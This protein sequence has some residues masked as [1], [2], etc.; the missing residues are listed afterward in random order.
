MK[1]ALRPEEDQLKENITIINKKVSAIFKEID[2]VVVGQDKVLRDIFICLL[3]RGHILL[4]G[5]PGLAKTLMIRAMSAVIGGTFKRIQF[6][7]DLLPTDITGFEGYDPQRG[8]FT[9]KGPVFA[10]FVLADE[11]NRAPPKVQSAL[12]EVMQ[13][14]Q[15][16]IGKTTFPLELPFIVLATENPIENKGT[17]SLPEAQLDRF[18]FKSL[19]DYPNID[20]EK[21]IMEKNIS[22][23]NFDEFKLEVVCTPQDILKMQQI[24]KMIF[25][26]D[27]I[28]EYI[29]QI[30]DA[31]RNPDSYGISLGKFIEWGGSPRAS[32]NLYIAS[33]AHALL[34]GRS[35]VVPQDIK[36]IALNVLR[37]RILLTYDAKVMGVTSERVIHEILSKVK[38]P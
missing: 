15:V 7:A 31:T 20:E 37:H 16:T 13:E 2:K 28:K 12:M 36:D 29:A 3:A 33:K 4:E 24:T 17:Y 35:F 18:L 34:E 27:K 9:F 32:I 11:I 1:E 8:F 25:L 38:V 21:I 26:H 23:H 19:V 10:H 22:I 30:I 6:T 14:L 5:A